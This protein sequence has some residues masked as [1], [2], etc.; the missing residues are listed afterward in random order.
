MLLVYDFLHFSSQNK[1]V[2][3]KQRYCLGNFTKLW[4]NRRPIY[5]L[6]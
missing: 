3:S 2:S 1:V 5:L 4:K 6:R